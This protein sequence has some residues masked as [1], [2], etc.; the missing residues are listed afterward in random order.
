M[1]SIFYWRGVYF[2]SAICLIIGCAGTSPQKQLPPGEMEIRHTVNHKLGKDA[3]FDLVLEWLAT[4]YRDASKV[5]QV[6]NKEKGSFVIR[7]LMSVPMAGLEIN[8]SY[9]IKIRLKDQR[10]LIVFETGLIE[11]PDAPYYNGKYPPKNNMPSVLNQ[12]D[13]I[14][15][16]FQSALQGDSSLDDF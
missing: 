5:I 6:K 13:L 14:L 12:Y 7:A 9:T 11:Q 10:S 4:T 8:V 16:S 2:F 1:K 15:S 3:S